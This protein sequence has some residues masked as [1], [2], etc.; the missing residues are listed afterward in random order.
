MS[1]IFEMLQKV[2]QDKALL[3]L[4]I[5]SA[6]TNSQN[7]E[8]LHQVGRSEQLFEA[9]TPAEVVQGGPM[10]PLPTGGFRGVTFKL[11]QQLYLA[12]GCLAPHV[13]V[14]CATEQGN[15]RDGICARVAELL[16][17][18][19]RG[20]IC[21][22]DANVASP[23]LHTYFEVKNRKGF[24]AA[25]VEA[26]PVKNFIQQVGRDRLW[27]MPAGVPPKGA[28][29]TSALTLGRL[30]ARIAELRT[31]FRHVLVDASPVFGNSTAAYLSSLADGVILTVERSF[32]PR[33]AARELKEEIEAAGGRVLGVV[34]HRRALPFSDR[35]DSRRQHQTRSQNS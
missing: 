23:W 15:E 22:V 8:V 30:A 10:P 20:S 3:N 21:V 32:T 14:F 4:A 11:I 27:V 9:A 31:S 16:A 35:T 6:Q 13:L 1:R 29:A 24:R 28:E 2:Q 17:S 18:H 7:F 25:M 12:P 34:L 33:Q 26:D 5:P 19:A